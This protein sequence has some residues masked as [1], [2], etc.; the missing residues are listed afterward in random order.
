[1][2]N[3]GWIK[4]YRKLLQSPIFEN[5]KALKVWVW[6]LCKATHVEREQLVGKQLVHLEKGQFI[7]GREKASKEL[8]MNGRTI[9][10]YFM[11]LEN[12]SMIHIKS[13]NKF[14]IIS[15]VNWEEYQTEEIKSNINFNN[16]ATTTQHKQEYK[17]IYIY[18]INK[19]KSENQKNFYSKMKFLREIKKDERYKELNPNEEDELRNLILGENI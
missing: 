14:S 9:Y 18:Y 10:D 12:L 2:E 15:I 17:E 1:M 19:Y 3:N 5:E 4:L 8:K 7:T 6:C 11:L 16:N 13:N